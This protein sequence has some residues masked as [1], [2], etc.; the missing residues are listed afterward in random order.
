M[1]GRYPGKYPGWQF[2]S[3]ESG[4]R[5]DILPFEKTADTGETSEMKRK[6]LIVAAVI[7]AAAAIL[8]VKRFLVVS[9]QERKVYGQPEAAVSSAELENADLVRIATR[10][11]RD[12]GI[13]TKCVMVKLDGAF[14]DGSR[15]V[16]LVLK[17]GRE[18]KG[19]LYRERNR[20]KIAADVISM[21]EQ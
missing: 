16:I 18:M 1:A 14:P 20:L 13:E 3:L 4:R 21:F 17:N 12:R 6:I 7:T 19:R 9:D 10:G 8:A 5:P 15:K 2:F 11:L